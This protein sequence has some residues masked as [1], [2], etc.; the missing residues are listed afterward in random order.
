MNKQRIK[1][2]VKILGL[3]IF[4]MALVLLMSKISMQLSVYYFYNDTGDYEAYKKYF[5]IFMIISFTFIISF[6]LFISNTKLKMLFKTLKFDISLLIKL[7]FF[8]FAIYFLL[9]TNALDDFVSISDSVKFWIGAIQGKKFISYDAFFIAGKNI[10]FID[11][12]YG[13]LLVPA[14]EEIFFRGIIYNKLK[15]VFSIKLA[16]FISAVLFAFVH[17]QGY[18]FKVDI[19]GIF[20]AGLMLAH[21]Y[22]KTKTLITPI[23][24]HCIS[25]I[26]TRFINHLRIDARI[27]LFLI[28]FITAIIIVAVDMVKYLRRRTAGNAVIKKD[29]NL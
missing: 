10:D 19:I 6:L 15:E 7:L 26:C 20:F 14:F 13:I 5:F 25:N 18:G 2:C 3:Y 9:R 29:I 8:E 16:I 12:L 27:L 4:Y 28:F 17:I 11:I 1:A 24:L 21:C 23:V 22:E